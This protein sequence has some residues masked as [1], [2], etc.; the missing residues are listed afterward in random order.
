MDIKTVKNLVA[1][2]ENSGLNR[3]EVE[4]N[5]PDGGSFRICLEK[6]AGNAS[7]V[8]VRE[9]LPPQPLEQTKKPTLEPMNEGVFDY[10]LVDAVTSPMVGVF[11]ASPSPDAPAFVTKGQKVKKGDTLCIIESMK[12]M[13]E[14]PAERDGEVVEICAQNG[15]LVEFGQVLF[16]LF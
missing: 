2:L 8:I 9:N 13:N 12:L 7:Q 15:S 1:I 10:N 14:I 5:P 4:D 11:Y 16:K 3:L 6:S